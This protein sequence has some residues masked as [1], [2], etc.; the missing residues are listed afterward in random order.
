MKLHTEDI[1]DDIGRL[2]SELEEYFCSVLKVETE[3]TRKIVSFQGNKNRGFYRW[4]KYKE[5]FSATLVEYFLEKY[6]IP[7]GT[8]FDPFAGIGTTMF[9]SSLLGFD[10]EG[11]ELL[12]VGQEIIDTRIFAQ[13]E[14]KQKELLMERGAG[15]F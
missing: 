13:F 5:A 12:P 1:I 15:V 6:N 8:I 11:I 9:A 2:E 10:A 3:L 7:N 4:Y 14:I